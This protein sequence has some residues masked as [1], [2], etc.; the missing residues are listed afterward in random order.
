[1]KSKHDTREEL[2]YERKLIMLEYEVAC[3]R[4]D[5]EV[6]SMLKEIDDRIWD[7]D[8]IGFRIPVAK[9]VNKKKIKK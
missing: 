1:M 5:N 4:I 2:Q 6:N 7:L 8:R 3:E 9:V